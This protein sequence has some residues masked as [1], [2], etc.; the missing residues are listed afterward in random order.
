MT[1][2]TILFS[3]LPTFVYVVDAQSTLPRDPL[4]A[5]TVNVP[6]RGYCQSSSYGVDGNCVKKSEFLALQTQMQELRQE[7]AR[8]KTEIPS[9][10]RV[11]QCSKRN[12]YDNRQHGVLLECV[13]EKKHNDTVLRI[14]WNGDLRLLHAGSKSQS[15]RRWYFS[16]NDKECSVPD[17]IDSI[18]IA[19]TNGPSLHKPAYVD[20]YCRGVPAG[21]VNVA[22]NVGDCPGDIHD[23]YGIGNSFTGWLSTSRIIIQEEIVENAN[24]TIG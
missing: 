2:P 21:T 3:L 24:N 6:E 15:C 5:C 9:A 19:S 11:M 18:L 4:C 20:G 16:L 10:S 1:R 23:R 22:W 7:L 17:T 14:A 13:F 12:M 8:K